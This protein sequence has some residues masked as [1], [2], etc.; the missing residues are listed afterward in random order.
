MRERA[1]Q[2]LSGSGLIAG[3]ESLLTWKLDLTF[4][5]HRWSPGLADWC[6]FA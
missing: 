2:E 3:S 5:Q 6:S 4:L 1:C